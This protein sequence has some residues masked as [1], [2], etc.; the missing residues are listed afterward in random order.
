MNVIYIIIIAFDHSAQNISA[1]LF[2]LKFTIK[3]KE[4]ANFIIYYKKIRKS[5]L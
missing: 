1:N 4:T 2:N 5:K 3:P